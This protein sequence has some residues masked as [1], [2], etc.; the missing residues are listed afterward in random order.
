MK[1]KFSLELH[2]H[3]FARYNG[4]QLIREQLWQNISS[5]F[6]GR[7]FLSIKLAV[8][9]TES[10]TASCATST[11]FV[12]EPVKASLRFDLSLNVITTKSFPLASANVSLLEMTTSLAVSEVETASIMPGV[13]VASVNLFRISQIF[14]FPSVR[15]RQKQGAKR[16]RYFSGNVRTTS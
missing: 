8:T 1:R 5:L 11:L 16:S 9:E 4:N 13:S 15:E 14:F 2:L 10:V 7:Y 12:F 6:L 3:L